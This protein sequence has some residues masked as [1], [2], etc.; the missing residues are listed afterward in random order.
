[1]CVNVNLNPAYAELNSDELVAKR[2]NLDRI[3]EFSKNLQNFNS[4]AI[5]QQPKLPPSSEKRDIALSQQ[6]LNSN[7][8]RAIEFAKNVPKPKVNRGA[9][10]SIRNNNFN[11]I[12]YGAEGGDGRE[13]GEGDYDEE[14]GGDGFPYSTNSNHAYA[15]DNTGMQMGAEFLQESR[16]LEL[17]TKHK[18]SKLQI[19]AMRKTLGLK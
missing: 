17:E 5:R 19:D 18:N 1:M 7:R 15:R 6:K 12:Q 2:A 10:G 9:Q 14:E 4:E 11:N 3:K 8:Q 13:G 16:I